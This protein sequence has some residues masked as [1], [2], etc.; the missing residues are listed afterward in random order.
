MPTQEENLAYEEGQYD[1]FTFA[2]HVLEDAA[3]QARNDSDDCPEPHIAMA[4]AAVF[5]AL[6]VAAYQLKEERE[7]GL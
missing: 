4:H 7:K 2:I 5:S 6:T 1:A 3:E